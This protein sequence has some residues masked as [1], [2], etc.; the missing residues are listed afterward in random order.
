MSV[1]VASRLLLVA[2]V[3]VSGCQPRA[4]GSSGAASRPAP[5]APD[6]FEARTI[7]EAECR[8]EARCGGPDPSCYASCAATPVRRPPIWDARW[9]SGVAAC[10]DHASCA[11]DADEACVLGPGPARQTRALCERGAV[12]GGD[13]P[14]S[15]WSG[16]S[17]GAD[18]SIAACLSSGGGDRCM[19]PLDWK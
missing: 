2:L 10:I 16:L 5:P 1:A 3:V 8:L 9:A 18:A 13:V 11:H 15:L 19:P 12:S 7:C 4:R 17:P 14:C 6:G